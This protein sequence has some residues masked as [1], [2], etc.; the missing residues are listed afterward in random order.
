MDKIFILFC[1]ESDKYHDENR[2]HFSED[3]E[4]DLKSFFINME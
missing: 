1:E 3:Y 2:K 4:H